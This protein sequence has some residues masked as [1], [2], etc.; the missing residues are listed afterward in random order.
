[1]FLGEKSTS[2]KE[3]PKFLGGTYVPYVLKILAIIVISYLFLYRLV[4]YHWKGLEE[5]YNFVV[6]NILI[7][8]Q[9]KKL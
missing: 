1:L 6:E 9:M 8:T 5:S 7:K 2:P 4:T 3:R